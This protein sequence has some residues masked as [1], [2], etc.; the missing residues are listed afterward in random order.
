MKT[1]ALQ[2]LLWR[3]LITPDPNSAPRINPAFFRSGITMTQ[4]ALSHRLAGTSEASRSSARTVAASLSFLT[5]SLSSAA[6]AV[7]A[8]SSVNRDAR[9]VR[10]VLIIISPPRQVDLQ[11][12]GRRTCAG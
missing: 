4:R 12:A 8:T 9:I 5:S 3:Q 1:G 11:D 2:P 6:S 7:E 10:E